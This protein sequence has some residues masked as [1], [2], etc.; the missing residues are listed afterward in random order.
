[1]AS[2]MPIRIGYTAQ[3]AVQREKKV[4]V[5][6]AKSCDLSFEVQFSFKMPVKYSSEGQFAISCKDLIFV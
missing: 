5:V 6:F 1:M 2:H 3:S 4:N